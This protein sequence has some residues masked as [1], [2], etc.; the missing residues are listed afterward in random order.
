MKQSTTVS[1]LKTVINYR[2]EW[3]LHTDNI[4]NKSSS[5]LSTIRKLSNLDN[6]DVLI[7]I[8]Y[9]AVY[10]FLYYGTVVWGQNA[11][12]CAEGVSALQT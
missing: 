7:F 3:E 1:N 5:S 2:D 4:C 8:Y 6:P 9:S 12:K 11:E 10:P